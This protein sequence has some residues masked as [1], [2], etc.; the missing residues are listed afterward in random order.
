MDISEL[1]VGQAREL[2]A[3]FGG[4]QEPRNSAYEIG[5]K[6]F[7]RTVTHIVTGR[8]LSIHDDGLVVTDAAWVADTGRYADAISSCKFKEVEPY[9][10]G[11]RVVV[12]FAAMIDAACIETL[13]DAQK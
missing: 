7:F 10:K 5:G 4:G 6:Y 8:L 13:P 12:N 1:T 2:A 3:L 11:A 9:P